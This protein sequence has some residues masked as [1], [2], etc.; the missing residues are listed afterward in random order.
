M[1][2]RCFDV[3]RGL[4]LSQEL[5]DLLADVDVMKITKTSAND[6]Y[7]FHIQSDRL[8]L[9]ENIFKVESA[10]AKQVFAGTDT[11]VRLV[12]KYNLSKQYDVK[13][14]W[15]IYYDSLLLEYKDR[16][17]IV[18][19]MLKNAQYE[20]TDETHLTICLAESIISDAYGL[21]FK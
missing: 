16:D 20:F 2:Q 3:F 17:V 8:I 11:K 10:I 21:N 9:K 12:E 7:R 14:L 19:S 6:I 4:N 13:K 5:H 1:A 18:F 15:D